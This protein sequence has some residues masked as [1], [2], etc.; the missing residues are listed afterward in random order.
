MREYKLTDFAQ[1]ERFELHS[2]LTYLFEQLE[3]EVPKEEQMAI[4]D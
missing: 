4:N 2:Y 1:E 3:P